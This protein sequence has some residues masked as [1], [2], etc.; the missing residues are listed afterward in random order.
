MT[1]MRKTQDPTTGLTSSTR[2]KTMHGQN[3]DI[4]PTKF[5]TRRDSPTIWRRCTPDERDIRVGLLARGIHADK[6]NGRWFLSDAKSKR[7]LDSPPVRDDVAR[8]I[9]FGTEGKP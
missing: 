4:W 6:I 5:V 7:F 2:T 3:L 8:I 1:A 9:A